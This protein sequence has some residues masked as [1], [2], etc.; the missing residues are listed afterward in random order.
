M[1]S[2]LTQVGQRWA[3]ANQTVDPDGNG[4]YNRHFM[5]DEGIGYVVG[6]V[7]HCRWNDTRS[8]EGKENGQTN[9]FYNSDI[10]QHPW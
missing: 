1:K 9:M 5:L 4:W 7:E 6:P 2:H 8:D 10:G 3:Q